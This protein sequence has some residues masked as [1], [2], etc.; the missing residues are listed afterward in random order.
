MKNYSLSIIRTALLTTLCCAFLFS[1]D[2]AEDAVVPDS[3][4]STT[5]AISE[6][7]K[8]QFASLGF[9]VSDLTKVGNDYMVEGDMVVTQEALDNMLSSDPVIVNNAVGEQYRTFNLV[10]RNL[11]TIRIRSTNNNSRVLLAIDRA[12]FN[13]NQLGLTFRMERVG[14]N[15]SADI[16]VEI[17]SGTRFLGSAGFPTG[18]GRPWN[19]VLLDV[20]AFNGRSDDLAE[21]TTTH[22][23]GHCV[24]LRHSDWY[25]RSFSCGRGGNEEQP[26][27]GLGVVGIPGTVRQ[28]PESIMNSCGA[29][30]RSDGEFSRFD[31]VALRELY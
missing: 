12:I 10:S 25:D 13:F 29:V 1:C 3:T 31:Q 5:N 21:E 22:E 20:N 26:P 27:S 15:Q 18:N 2:D 4:S 9:D 19:R 7:V 8:S 23:L 30:T 16:T 24:G 11:R 6:E 14:A 17:V 28:D